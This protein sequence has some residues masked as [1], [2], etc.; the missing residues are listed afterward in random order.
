MG[1]SS[2]PMFMSA[3]TGAFSEYEIVPEWTDSVSVNL[4]LIRSFLARIFPNNNF[5]NNMKEIFTRKTFHTME[6]YFDI[7]GSRTIRIPSSASQGSNS[8]VFVYSDK[9][10]V[11]VGS[12]SSH[13]STTS[14]TSPSLL[15][16]IEDEDGYGVELFEYVATSPFVSSNASWKRLMHDVALSLLVLRNEGIMHGDIKLPNLLFQSNGSFKLCDFANGGKWSRDIVT[17]YSTIDC[18]PAARILEQAS[19]KMGIGNAVLDFRGFAVMLHE[20]ITGRYSNLEGTRLHRAIFHTSF[21]RKVTSMWKAL[22]ISQSMIDMW[23]VMMY[24]LAGDHADNISRSYD[25]LADVVR[26]CGSKFIYAPISFLGRTEYSD[27][28][29]DYGTYFEDPC[30]EATNRS[31][32]IEFKSW[33]TGEP[34]IDI[35][36]PSIWNEFQSPL[37]NVLVY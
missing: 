34:R 32:R 24:T 30:I 17:T 13:L 1:L 18:V 2:S 14:K 7:T 23:I 22:D 4:R 8:V 35:G 6:T 11:K 31:V 36:A 5:A 29:N 9:F 16:S 26:A 21:Y 28:L 15:Y 10:L 37:F 3:L 19:S 25:I 20:L 33:C 12:I 27:L